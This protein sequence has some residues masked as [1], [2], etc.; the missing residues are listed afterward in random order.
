[1]KEEILLSR[2]WSVLPKEQR[3]LYCLS[4]TLVC[5]VS[6][7]ET[8]HWGL[9]IDNCTATSGTALHECQEW[10]VR[11]YAKNPEKAAKMWKLS[12]K[13]VGQEFES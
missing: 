10:P 11:D 4:S 8:R 2:R 6:D 5:N 12:E 1:M 3:R 13:L 9:Q 7:F